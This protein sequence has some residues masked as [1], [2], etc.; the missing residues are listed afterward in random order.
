MLLGNS[1]LYTNFYDYY[2]IFFFNI[3]N[4]ISVKFNDIFIFLLGYDKEILYVA[5]GLVYFNRIAAGEY[6]NEIWT[7]MRAFF[8][9]LTC[10]VSFTYL[11]HFTFTVILWWKIYVISYLDKEN[12]AERSSVTYSRSYGYKWWFEVADFKILSPQ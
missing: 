6:Q 5:I 3:S 11:A 1:E 10:P 4:C 2:C 9:C 7:Q 12:R 8:K